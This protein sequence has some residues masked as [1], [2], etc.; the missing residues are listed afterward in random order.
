MHDSLNPLAGPDAA[1]RHVAE[2]HLRRRRRRADQHA[3]LPDHRRVPRRAD[4]GPHARVPGQEGRGPRDEAG[5]AGAAGPPALD[6]RRRPGCSPRP[7]GSTRPRTTPAPTGSARASTSSPRR[8]RTTARASRGSAT[9]TGF[10]DKD[11]NPIAPA[12][13]APHW[14]I[15]CG[16]VM[17][18]GRFIP[19]IA[20]IAFAASLARK[21]PTP[22]TAR[23]AADRHDHVRLRA[24][25][26]DPAG[27]GADVP[28]GRGPRAGG[29]APRPAAVRPLTDSRG[30]TCE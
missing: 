13:F 9:R 29:R 22:F 28:A 24:A 20:P 11:K 5:D 21:K 6:P 30:R 10:N 4:G 12:P 7:G 17:L 14:D 18:F 23:H 15:A 25:G 1:D 27:R 19:I 16:L 3:D 2:L 26:D 8:P